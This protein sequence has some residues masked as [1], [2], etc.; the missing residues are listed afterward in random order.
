MTSTTE[1][2]EAATRLGQLISEHPA[3][4]KYR[5]VLSAIRE[6]T[7]A[8]RLL[9]DYSRQ[10]DL[11]AEKE[12]EGKPI[13]VE[14]KRK[15]SDLQGRIAMHAVLR[16]MQMAQMDYVDLMRKVDEAMAAGGAADEGES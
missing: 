15:L 16:E 14:D 8:Q 7:E 3:M 9:A 2:V 4:V 11:V 6:D 10:M 1:I 5:E 13:E 12:T